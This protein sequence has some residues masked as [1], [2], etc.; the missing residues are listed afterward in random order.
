[1]ATHLSSVEPSTMKPESPRLALVSLPV[2]VSIRTMQ[3]VELP[4]MPA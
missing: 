2:R 1:M 3:Q 4:L